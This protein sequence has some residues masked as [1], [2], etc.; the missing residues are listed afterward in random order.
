MKNKLCFSTY[1]PAFR[2]TP[3]LCDVCRSEVPAFQYKFVAEDEAGTLRENAGY[4]CVACSGE[5]LGNLRT[6]ELR[7]WTREEAAL[8]ADDMDI[9]AIREHRLALA[10]ED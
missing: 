10:G 2:D 8:A 6:A 9:T 4:C 7:T 5:L 3:K 1:D